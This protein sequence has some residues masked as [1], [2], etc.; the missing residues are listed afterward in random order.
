MTH[1]RTLIGR[2]I[3]MI[4]CFREIDTRIGCDCFDVRVGFLHRGN[5]IR[6]NTPTIKNDNEVTIPSGNVAS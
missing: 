6:R 2:N 5:F 1:I 4:A 3:A